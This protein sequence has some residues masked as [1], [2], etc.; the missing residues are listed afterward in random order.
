MFITK[1]E[2][3][4]THIEFIGKNDSWRFNITIDEKNPEE[5]SYYLVTKNFEDLKEEFKKETCGSCIS[6]YQKLDKKFIERF[7][8]NVNKSLESENKNING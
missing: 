6:D 1:C 2:E 3:G 5:S 7:N 4:L 8:I